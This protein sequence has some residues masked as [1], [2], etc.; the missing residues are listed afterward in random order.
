MRTAE[1]ELAEQAEASYKRILTDQQAAAP[2][3]E[4]GRRRDTGARI[5]KALEG[6]SRAADSKLLTSALRYV[7][8]PRP[9]TT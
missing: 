4:S 1:R 8:H 7:S 5:N 6:Q 9:R 2:T 3:R